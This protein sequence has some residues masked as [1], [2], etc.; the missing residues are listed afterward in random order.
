MLKITKSSE[1]L[2]LKIFKTNNNKVI[3][4]VDGGRANKTVKNLFKS[5][6]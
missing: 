2:A 5:K 1:L 4:D 6:K 3:R